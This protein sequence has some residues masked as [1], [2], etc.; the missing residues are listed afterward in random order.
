MSIFTP[1]NVTCPSCGEAF[2]V[3]V[4]ESVNADR[5]PDLREEILQ[6]TF[7]VVACGSCHE[8]VRLDPL[9]NYLDVG[10]GQWFSVQP[11][12]QMK[13]W[14]EQEDTA[15]EVFAEAYGDQAS[16]GAREIGKDLKPRLVFGWPALREKLRAADLGMNDVALE[17]AKLI[18]IEEVSAKPL[19]QGAELRLLGGEGDTVDMAWVVPDGDE[20]I[21][22]MKV[23]MELY[24]GVADK[25]EDWEAVILQLESG[26]FVDILKLFMGEGRAETAA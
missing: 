19:E 12:E 6:G 25:L 23:P 10:R 21:E 5:R 7:Q 9:F 3:D 20:I 13:N 11:A 26:P 4:V 16:G 22:G 15:M 2:D 18:L 24:Q 1:L 8:E 14:V 17:C